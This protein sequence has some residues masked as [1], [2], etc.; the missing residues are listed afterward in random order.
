MIVVNLI[1]DATQQLFKVSDTP[2]LDAEVLLCHVLEK[3]R[4]YLISWPEKE[5]EGS[6]LKKFQ[7]LLEQRQQG[8]PVAHIIQQREF[9][10]LNFQVSND[11]LIPRPDTELIVEKIL[12]NHAELP[13]KSLLDLGTG[14]GA[15]AVAIASERPQWNII[16]TDQS[17]NALQLAEKNALQ[18]GINNIKFK[19]G[20]WFEAIDDQRFDIIVSN[21]P[22]IAE[23]DPH[24][25]QGDVRFEP[26][27]AL[28]S[29]ADGLND[30]R[31]I[32][33]HARQHLNSNGMLII[34]HGYD[35][36]K[37]VHSIFEQA[38]FKDIQQ[39]HDLAHQPRCTSGLI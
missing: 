8:H 12:N 21:P 32:T 6:Q 18:H 9:W 24:L 16:A 29:G 30:I 22:Y 38:G 26:S 14:S 33:Q 37:A 27:S 5:I 11:T 36:K 15:I 10:S 19:P 28:V 31:L 23:S 34:E 2:K 1:N 39:H 13:A 25:N 35:Q 3:D 4:S 7:H 20:N 17:L